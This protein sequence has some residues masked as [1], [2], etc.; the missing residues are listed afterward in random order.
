MFIKRLGPKNI[1]SFADCPGLE[2]RNLNLLI[3]PNGAGKSNLIHVIELLHQLPG[4]FVSFMVNSRGADLW[5]RLG[6]GVESGMIDARFSLGEHD[7]TYGFTFAADGP[8]AVIRTEQLARSAGIE[9]EIVIGRESGTVYR[10]SPAET[11]TLKPNFA[12]KS[13]LGMF[14]GPEESS[15]IPELAANLDRIRIYRGFDVGQRSAIRSGLPASRSYDANLLEDGSNLAEVLQELDHAGR[16]SD[17]NRHLLTLNTQAIDLRY[18]VTEGRWIVSVEERQLSRRLP[19]AI[20]SDGTLRFLCLAAILMD[21]NPPPLICLE[22]PEVGLHPDAIRIVGEML[23]DASTR[24]QLVV[25]T[26]SP[27]LIDCFT[28]DPESVIVCEKNLENETIFRRYG[29][30]ELES[31]LEDFTLGDVWQRGAIGGVL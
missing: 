4:D 9:N 22:E 1:L 3:G 15:V 17:I 30:S 25:T 8:V 13:L 10:S 31:W 24:T 20:L 21:P 27:A 19:G 28:S 14:R 2:L 18:R 29:S 7:W 26:H 5:L 23:V 6:A 12:S 16:L 11:V